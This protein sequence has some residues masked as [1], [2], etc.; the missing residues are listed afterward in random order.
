MTKKSKQKTGTISVNQE[1]KTDLFDV[2]CGN[3]DSK[4]ACQRFVEKLEQKSQSFSRK[5][6]RS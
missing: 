2:L 3:S 5:S 4:E 6:P 1:Q